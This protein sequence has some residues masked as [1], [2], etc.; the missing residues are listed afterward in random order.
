MTL[1]DE[2]GGFRRVRE[3]NMRQLMKTGSTISVA[4]M[5]CVPKTWWA[6][7]PN[8]NERYDPYIMPTKEQLAVM[9]GNKGY[10]LF[11]GIIMGVP[12]HL[13]IIEQHG[14]RRRAGRY[15]QTYTDFEGLDCYSMTTIT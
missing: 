13:E 3:K 11:S 1:S 4:G 14:W 12:K 9:G 10:M 5:V 8:R 2:Y 6:I 15:E 7:R